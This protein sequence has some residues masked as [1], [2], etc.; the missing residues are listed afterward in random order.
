MHGMDYFFTINKVTQTQIADYLGISKT[1]PTSWK[2]GSKNFPSKYKW[3]LYDLFAIPE[4]KQYLLEKKLINSIDRTEIELIFAQR[5]LK[6]IKEE[7]DPELDEVVKGGLIFKFEQDIR[8]CQ[9]SIKKLSVLENLKREINSSLLYDDIF[10]KKLDM[11]ENLI[12][13][14]KKI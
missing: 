10:H 2:N 5:R 4:D 6:E 11:V 9:M 7:D 12:E 13:E 8:I 1:A 14:M 3:K